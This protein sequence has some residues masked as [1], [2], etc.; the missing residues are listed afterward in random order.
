MIIQVS[1][2]VLFFIVIENAEK[3]K[4]GQ[5]NCI[6]QWHWGANY[7]HDV[8]DD[9][10]ECW[11]C[12]PGV[13]ENVQSVCSREKNTCGFVYKICWYIIFKDL[14]GRGYKFEMLL[15]WAD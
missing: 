5:V 14:N 6:F 8:H 3:N 15:T 13:Q 2:V 7:Y 1:V 12:T 4:V 11:E 10:L 9:D